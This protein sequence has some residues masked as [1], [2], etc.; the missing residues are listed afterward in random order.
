[1]A[2]LSVGCAWLGFVRVLPALCPDSIIPFQKGCQGQNIFFQEIWWNQLPGLIF[3]G[4]WEM[5]R[6]SRIKEEDEEVGW[7]WLS[8][9]RSFTGQ[10][11]SEQDRGCAPPSTFPAHSVVDKSKQLNWPIIWESFNQGTVQD[12]VP[13]G[14]L[15][16]VVVK[17]RCSLKVLSEN[18]EFL[19][20][21]HTGLWVYEPMLP[22][23]E[24]HFKRMECWYLTKKSRYAEWKA[25]LMGDNA[26]I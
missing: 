8:T 19:I 1:M 23:S 25:S 17:S 18:H 20:I 21:F 24:Y 3:E 16:V 6:Y 12:K 22:L 11:F 13:H 4:S 10:E 14:I 7:D 15:S 2:P 9:C 5:L 26:H